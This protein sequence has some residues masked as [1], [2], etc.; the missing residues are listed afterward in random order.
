MIGNWLSLAS[1]K[2]ILVKPIFTSTVSGELQ[3]GME[4]FAEILNALGMLK[5]DRGVVDL[6]YTGLFTQVAQSSGHIG[7]NQT[8]L[9]AE[10][11][12]HFTIYDKGGPGMRV[13]RKAILAPFYKANPFGHEGVNK[14]M[15]GAGFIPMFF[16]T[17]FFKNL[18][19][20]EVP[21]ATNMGDRIDSM[22]TL[23]ISLSD[24]NSQFMPF[25]LGKNQIVTLAAKL[26]FWDPVSR[27]QCLAL[28]K[29]SDEYYAAR[30]DKATFN[31]AA[32]Q[33][34]R[35]AAQ[36]YLEFLFGRIVETL[37]TIGYLQ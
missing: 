27:S 5:F 14:K 30:R 33:C 24:P 1:G 19:T 13:D 28:K 32:K 12:D 9:C 17:N 34:F 2:T 11:Y 4:R 35:E 37:S 23:V 31:Y 22:E 15:T 20:Q 26:L 6:T 25:P 3:E 21:H 16:D 8:L 36:S 10:P 29:L 18:P 7:L